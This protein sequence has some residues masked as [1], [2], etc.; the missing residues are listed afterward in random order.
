M[1]TDTALTRREATLRSAAT[2]CLAGIALLQA[3]ELP[4]LFAQGRQVAVLSLLAM[5]I[6]IVLGWLLAAGPADAGRQLWRVVAG[7]SGLVLTGWV[8]QHAV[9]VPGLASDAGN[10]LS[11][12]GLISGGL[13]AICL[14]VAIVAAPPTRA[15]IRGLA[16][17]SA[18]CLALAPVAAIGVVGLGPGTAGGE[19][20]LASGGHLHSHGSPENSIVYRDGRYV[21][22]TT[23]P[24]RTTPVGLGLM[25]AATF[26]FTYGAVAYL[27]RR[28][29]PADSTG[30]AALDLER[31]LA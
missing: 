22:K 17:A 5:G 8:V 6:C 31:G 20:V 3:I 29:M 1:D 24:P 16:A 12:P 4:P 28:S 13:A 21:F 18:V 19:T 23:T 9:A 27:R 30:L 10:W 7:I 26:V 15:G 11:M 14:G 25:L 2:T